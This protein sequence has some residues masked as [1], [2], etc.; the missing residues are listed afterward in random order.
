MVLSVLRLIPI[1]TSKSNLSQNYL[2]L[3]DQNST[4]DG[5]P[6]ILTFDSELGVLILA[7]DH[8]FALLHGLFA[9][10]HAATDYVQLPVLLATAEF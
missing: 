5:E 8:D 4:M 2:W 3:S 9:A 10:G 1:C 6:W 7:S